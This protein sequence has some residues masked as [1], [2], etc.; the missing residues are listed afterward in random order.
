LHETSLVFRKS[1][2]LFSERCFERV[3][4]GDNGAQNPLIYNKMR[5]SIL[6]SSPRAIGLTQVGSATRRRAHFN[7]RA[8]T[9]RKEFGLRSC[10]NPQKKE[11][12]F[13]LKINPFP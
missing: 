13:T 2:Q 11:R 1:A 12:I 4:I 8:A 9:S 3:K 10:L 6:Y 7:P 5:I